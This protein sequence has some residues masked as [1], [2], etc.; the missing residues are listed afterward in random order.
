MYFFESDKPK[1]SMMGRHFMASLLW[2]TEPGKMLAILK[3]M[4]RTYEE[5][6]LPIDYN[7]LGIEEV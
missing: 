3:V 4:M 2:N 7:A 1:S 6:Q 5:Y